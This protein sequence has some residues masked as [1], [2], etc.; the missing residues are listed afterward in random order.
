MFT[1]DKT[2]GMAMRI[3]SD[4]D[5]GYEKLRIAQQRMNRDETTERNTDALWR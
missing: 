5:D 4:R 1:R 3:R 2:L